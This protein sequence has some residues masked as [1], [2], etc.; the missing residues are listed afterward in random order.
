MKTKVNRTNI[1]F[2]DVQN[3]AQYELVYDAAEKA[4]CKLQA[5]DFCSTL[6][7]T[8]SPE[9]LQSFISIWNAQ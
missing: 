8:G 6:I 4:G 3:A 9:Q 7:I 1:T 2:R 5:K